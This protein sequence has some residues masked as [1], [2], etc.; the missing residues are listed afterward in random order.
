M[1]TL[2]LLLSRSRFKDNIIRFLH[3]YPNKDNDIRGKTDV[4]GEL[5]L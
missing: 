5:S 2:H 4:K 1:E 3:F